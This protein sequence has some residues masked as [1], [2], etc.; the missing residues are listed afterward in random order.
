MDRAMT[1]HLAGDYA[2]SNAAIEEGARLIEDLYTKSV[3]AEAASFLVND[4]S[5][6]YRGDHYERVMLHLLGMLNYSAL[7]Q[8]DDALVEARRA[9]ELLKGF[10]QEVGEDKLGYREDALARYVSALLYESGSRQD[11]WD[12][13]LDYK[14]ADE[15]YDLYAQLY[16]TPKPRRLKA[17]LQRLA[18]GLGENDDLARWRGRDGQLDYRPLDETRKGGK[19]ELIVLL[20]QGL[21]PAKISVSSTLPIALGDGTQ[22]Y[23]RLALPQAVVLQQPELQAKL[24]AGSQPAVPFELFQ[25]INA[26]AVR[27]L[28]DKAGALTLKAT[29]RAIAKFQAARQVQKQA[30]E[31]GGA[32][33][34]LAFLGTNLYTLF[35]E[36]AD[37]RSWR[38][39]PGRIYLARVSLD[40]G[41]QKVLVEVQAGGPQS[42]DF[43]ELDLKA[44]Q[45][46]FLQ[47]S[48]LAP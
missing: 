13:Y 37:T 9:D 4:M 33:E 5:L 31:A 36:T 28:Q 30:R 40:P 18:E 29:A 32:A 8:K 17:D 43:G 39:L 34:L 16:H 26:I 2:A 48:L 20:Y 14:K 24:L 25:D 27:D 44:G 11:L 45:K 38:T 22:Q 42:L 19:A 47:R 7:G 46:L 12:A 1:L 23:F 41:R 6:P 15:A 10:A 35:S 3:S 21:A